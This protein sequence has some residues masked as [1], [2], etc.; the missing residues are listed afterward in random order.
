MQTR[1]LCADYI[2]DGQ[3]LLKNKV[4]ILDADNR[5][6]ELVNKEDLLTGGGESAL[7]TYQGILTPGLI[8][9]HCHL[10]LSHLKGAIGEKT[11]LP[12]F[13][14]QVMRL[15][16]F[17]QDE[18]RAAIAKADT[19]MWQS[20]IQAV[21]DICN[22][23]DTLLQK[24]NSPIRYR[25]FVECLGFLPGQAAARYDYAFGEIQEPFF[26]QNPATTLVPHAPYSVSPDLFEK[27]NRSLEKIPSRQD[28]IAT[29]HNQES[30][31]ENE[32]FQKGTGAFIDFYNKMGIDIS[33]YMPEGKTSL[34]TVLPRLKA[35]D[36]LLLV[37]NT[38]STREDILFAQNRA[39]ASGQ[40]IVFVL[41]PGANLYIE[42]RLP[43]VPML[44]DAGVFIALGTDSLA[45]NHN[46]SIV[47]EMQY[48]LRSYP[49]LNK[50]DL[51]QWATYNGARALGFEKE[52]GS[53]AQGKKPGVVLLTEELDLIQRII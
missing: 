9:A 42:N 37:H 20:G 52:L 10:E 38:F 47:K 3:Q 39:A 48:L 4:L 44:M 24:Q 51:L 26:E 22:T 32:F 5:V 16:H 35:A 31:P 23:T 43:D 19:D 15:R 18:I 36:K 17:A 27:I 40:T 34:Q 33:F 49:D 21:G 7:E 12:G 2:F 6:R 53:F 8:N 30:A 46:L 11:G 13:V 45:S 28:R 1:K 14:S 29:M 25:N 41:C 50:E